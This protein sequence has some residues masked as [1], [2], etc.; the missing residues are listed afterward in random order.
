M[1]FVPIVTPE[2]STTRDKVISIISTNPDIKT[3]MISNLLKK[4]YGVN[5]SYQAVHKLLKQL[6]QEEVL[7]VYSKNYRL[8]QDWINNLKM[9]IDKLQNQHGSSNPTIRSLKKEG[10]ALTVKFKTLSEMDNFLISFENDWISNPDNKNQV[11]VWQQWHNRFPIMYPQDKY[12][13]AKEFEKQ[14]IPHYILCRGDTVLDNWAVN[15]YQEKNIFVRNGMQCSESCE[16]GIYGD[17][18]VEM[19]YSTESIMKIEETYA[20]TS[21]IEDLNLHKLFSDVLLKEG[22]FYIHLQKNKTIAD[23]V[24]NRMIELYLREFRGVL[25]HLK[26]QIS[27]GMKPIRFK[28]EYLYM[29]LKQIDSF[30]DVQKA[31]NDT[32]QEIFL[33][34]K[35]LKRD[36]LLKPIINIYDLGTGDGEKADKLIST[37]ERIKPA[38]LINYYA[39]DFS[40]KMLD[41]TTAKIKGDHPLLNIIQ[42][43]ADLLELDHKIVPNGHNQNN[44][45]IFLL[46]GNTYGNFES[47]KLL[48]MLHNLLGENDVL[49]IGM[50][51]MGSNSDTGKFVREYSTEADKKF[52]L[53]F[54][55]ELSLDE[56]NLGFEAIFNEK[57][58]RI[59]LYATIK[60]L[61]DLLVPNV[62]SLGLKSGQ[63][64]LM[65]SSWKPTENELVDQLSKYFDTSV[66]LNDDKTLAVVL[67]RQKP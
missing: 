22:D 20:S 60:T 19:F 21:K 47:Q 64:I 53:S 1:T 6:E 4:H 12:K 16:T 46:L 5:I 65:V 14:D 50:E 31:H 63:K 67:C 7:Q 40:Q 28:Q 55:S 3:V 66:A 35:T 17:I 42:M 9:F 39:V 44:V 37:I 8:N 26:K 49:V 30:L 10:D 29:T 2:K 54:F 58:Q 33:I 27:L 45:N 48:K 57:T 38:T 15:F 62:K 25:D 24:K 13:S 41:I 34:E 52:I 23:Q 56:S 61:P 59:E 11:V 32:F 18:I 36:S 51:L 43:K